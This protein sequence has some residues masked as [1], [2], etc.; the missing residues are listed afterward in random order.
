MYHK[1]LQ[2]SDLDIDKHLRTIYVLNTCYVSTVTTRDGMALESR[3]TTCTS[4]V[5]YLWW[6]RL[7]TC[8]IPNVK[9]FWVDRQ[10]VS[11][12]TATRI[13]KNCPAHFLQ[14]CSSILWLLLINWFGTDRVHSSTHQSSSL[15]LLKNMRTQKVSWLYGYPIWLRY[16]HR[17]EGKTRSYQTCS[18]FSSMNTRRQMRVVRHR[19][20]RV[21]RHQ[22]T[23]DAETI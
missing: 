23:P 17:K 18:F 19:F 22:W 2:I 7:L 13:D 15:R 6:S 14:L 11:P 5:H 12:V 8:Y 4:S 3:V 9:R 1:H 16:S 20:F 21:R 10:S